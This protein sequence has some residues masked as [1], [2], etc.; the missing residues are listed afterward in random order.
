MGSADTLVR[1][2][3]LSETAVPPIGRLPRFFS[4]ITP[5]KILHTSDWHLGHKLYG[6]QRYQE[7][8]LFLDWLLTVIESQKIEALL[9]AGDIFDSQTPSNRILEIYYHFL[10]SISHSPCRHVIIIGGNHDSPALLNAPRELLRFLDIHIIG[11][12][13]EN[14]ED[15][16]IILRDKSNRPELMVLAVPYLR[17]RDLRSAEAGESLHDKEKKLLMGIQDHY[18][19][20]YELAGQK[21]Q[22]L[23]N[24]VPMVATGHLF[25]QGGTTSQGDGVR[26]LYVGSLVHVGLD[27][28]PPELDYLALG[29]LH[30]PQKVSRQENRQ[31]SGAPLAMSFNEAN[32][33]KCVLA[34]TLASEFLVQEIPV[35]CFQALQTITGDLSQILEALHNLKEQDQSILLEINYSGQA[36]IDDLQEQ[37]YTAVADSPLDVLR[38]SNKRIYDHILQQTYEI[39]TLEELSPLQVFQQCLDLHEIEDEQQQEMLLTFETALAALQDEDN[40]LE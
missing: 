10:S 40:S 23:E 3:K 7:F 2:K 6:R 21:Q 27:T 8:S 36:L 22:S 35:P 15:E 20:L 37:I 28:F 30:L 14:L 4:C 13:P 32:K 17:D 12:V 26:E 16:I 31:Y 39:K 33:Q 11:R 5:M 38:I 24:P 18:S 1:C 19:K 29:H 25:C 34:V 9:V